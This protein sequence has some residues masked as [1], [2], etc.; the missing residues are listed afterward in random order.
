MLRVGLVVT[1]ILAACRFSPNAART[2]DAPGTGPGSDAALPDGAL[3]DAAAPDATPPPDASACANFTAKCLDSS[4]L[5]S[6][7]GSDATPTTTTCNWGCEATSPARCAEIVPA[8]GAVMT[9][10]LDPTG[11]ADVTLG[12]GT[13]IDTD[14]GT[15][16]GVATG[17]GNVLRGSVRVLEVKSLAITGPITIT[18]SKALALVANG[19]IAVGGVIDARGPCATNPRSAGPG[20]HDGG[21]SDANGPGPGGGT[22]GT[23]KNDGGGGG[24][25][26][27][28]GGVG[29]GSDAGG[30]NFGDMK[31]SMLVGGGGGGGGHNQGKG[32]GGGGAIQLVSNTSITIAANSGINAG[33]CGGTSTNNDNNAGGGGGG[34]GGT[35]LLE[36]PVVKIAGALAVNGGGGGGSSNGSAATLDRTPAPGGGTGGDGASA[37]T[38]RGSSGGSAGGG[39]GGL[40]RI[41]V[42]TRSGMATL[43]PGNVLSP[44]FADSTTATQAAATLQ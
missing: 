30:Q 20:G 26:G 10:D 33:G 37:G 32:G 36:A 42:N 44:S 6:C 31:I 2:A 8:G 22:G 39:G 4:T 16:T 17:Y 29:D 35:I 41:R 24:G 12:G 34:A 3:P 28:M 9:S 25:Y 13:T 21:A 40:G 11:L 18:G 7:S 15:I 38:N 43:M 27:G 19:A 5:E 23:G 14:D 1:A